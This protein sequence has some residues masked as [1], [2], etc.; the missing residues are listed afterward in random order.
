MNTAPSP[1]FLATL[2]TELIALR[3]FA[4]KLCGGNKTLAD[5]LVQETAVR[6][7]SGHRGFTY[8]SMRPWLITTLRNCLHDTRNRSSDVLAMD[9]ALLAER[10]RTPCFTVPLS[11]PLQR[12]MAK[13]LERQLAQLDPVT[14]QIIVL[15]GV[16]GHDASSTAARVGLTQGRVEGIYADTVE[17]LAKA[18]DEPLGKLPRDGHDGV[19]VRR[20]PPGH[21]AIAARRYFSQMPPDEAEALL[22]D[23]PTTQQSVMRQMLEGGMS[24]AQV[25][26]RLGIS[27]GTVKSAFSRACAAISRRTG[28]QLAQPKTEPLPVGLQAAIDAHLATLS[29]GSRRPHATC[30]RRV[31]AEPAHRDLTALS[32]ARLRSY[33][34]DNRID[35]YPVWRFFEAERRAGRMPRNPLPKGR[36]LSRDERLAGVPA[37]VAATVLAYQAEKGLPS[38]TYAIIMRFLEHSH[39]EQRGDINAAAADRYLAMLTPRSRRLAVHDL[40]RFVD[41]CGTEQAPTRPGPHPGPT[42]TTAMERS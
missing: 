5:D 3:P 16:E 31:F 13:D 34:A 14:R 26:A 21:I 36:K 19:G 17:A 28:A 39:V 32:G 27:E 15:M 1:Q 41:W 38:R 6:A 8:G 18:I 2:E 33:L 35:A 10:H 37:S 7:L 42:D 12:L 9:P 11:D 25:A 4:V 24:Q 30:L 22:R 29:A 40:T 20:G 23:L